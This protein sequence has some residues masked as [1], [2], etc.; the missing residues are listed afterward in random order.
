MDPKI[1]A[2]VLTM[3]CHFFADMAWMG[4]LQINSLGCQD[5]RP[6]YRQAL[7]DFL[8]ARLDLLRRLQAARR[9][10]TLCGRWTARSQ[11]A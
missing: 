4:A 10:P 1:D 7:L 3:L 6:E 11:A 2:Q 9:T 8:Q 5:C